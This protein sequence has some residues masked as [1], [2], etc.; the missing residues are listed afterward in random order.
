MLA[1]ATLA[2][3]A[4]TG[5]PERGYGPLKWG[6]LLAY[7]IGIELLQSQ[8]PNRFFGRP[9]PRQ[10][11]RADRTARRPAVLAARDRNMINPD[12]A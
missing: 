11:R 4:D 9:T 12:T 3:L 1:F 8:I 5:W 6:T 7:G 2:L 10:C